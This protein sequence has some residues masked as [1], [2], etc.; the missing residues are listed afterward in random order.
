MSSYFLSGGSDGIFQ[1]SSLFW[2][3]ENISLVMEQ[4]QV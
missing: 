2:V 1:Y 3:S 4:Y